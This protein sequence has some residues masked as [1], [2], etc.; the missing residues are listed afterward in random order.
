MFHKHPIDMCNK[1]FSIY[2]MI[3]KTIN[4]VNFYLSFMHHIYVSIIDYSRLIKEYITVVLSEFRCSGLNC[5]RFILLQSKRPTLSFVELSN[6]LFLRSECPTLVFNRPNCPIL[7]G[8][9]QNVQI[10]IITLGLC[11]F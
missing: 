1:S 7:C 6:S 8:Y 3:I 11:D 10:L 4:I 5:D 9:G 2:I